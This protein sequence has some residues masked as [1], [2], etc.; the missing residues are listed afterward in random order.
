MPRSQGFESKEQEVARRHLDVF[1]VLAGAV[2]QAD[3][4]VAHFEDVLG[5][6]QE[7]HEGGARSIGQVARIERILSQ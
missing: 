6:L 5:V 4:H 3:D 1:G 2:L 7:C